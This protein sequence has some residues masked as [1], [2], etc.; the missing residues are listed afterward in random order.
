[1]TIRCLEI[2]RLSPKA[3]DYQS[4]FTYCIIPS[5]SYLTRAGHCCLLALLPRPHIIPSSKIA[6]KVNFSY[7][8][9]YFLKNKRKLC[10]VHTYLY[11]DTF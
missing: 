2:S 1:M 9:L 7:L 11:L 10:K 5:L 8:L 6:T 4:K 3:V